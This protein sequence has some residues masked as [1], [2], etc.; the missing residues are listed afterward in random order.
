M[1]HLRLR[2]SPS[3]A[4]SERLCRNAA[5]WHSAP[6]TQGSVTGTLERCV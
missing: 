6:Q 2:R 5:W 4:G 1:E 3:S